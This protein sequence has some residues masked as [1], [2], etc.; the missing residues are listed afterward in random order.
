V[1]FS[2]LASGSKANSIFIRSGDTA[3]L[4]DCGLSRRET[5]KRLS[6]LSVSPEE[7]SAIVVTHEH[8]DHISGVRVLANQS[9]LP[10]YL[11]EPTFSASRKLQEVSL[12]QIFFFQE[13]VP[14]LIGGLRLF[15]FSLSHDAAQAVGF[16][17]TDGDK[18]ISV[19]TDLGVYNDSVLDY[20]SDADA[21][22]LES[23]HETE[24]LWLSEYPWELK[25]RIAGSYGHLSNED[26]SKF[27]FDLIR[28]GG[29]RRLRFVGAGH[30]SENSNTYDRALQAVKDSWKSS[31]SC[32][33]FFVARQGES[34]ECFLV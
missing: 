32:P 28:R 14:F 18:C 29:H 7:L 31:D 34:T 1:E 8:E 13:G 3:I 33:H 26:A 24:Q 15:P 9:G 22:I 5:I 6:G 30:V 12:H 25:E 19:V 16:R 20:A 17:V 4:L 27:V 23:N 11:N 2:V 10:V 21:L